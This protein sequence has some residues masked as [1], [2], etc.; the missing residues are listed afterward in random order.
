MNIYI[1]GKA[2]DKP[3]AD[4][5]ENFHFETVKNYLLHAVQH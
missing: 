2:I 4:I 3:F 1:S 5:S